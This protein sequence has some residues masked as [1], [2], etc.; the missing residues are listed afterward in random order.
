MSNAFAFAIYLVIVW[1]E[2]LTRLS[3]LNSGRFFSTVD[4]IVN[5]GEQALSVIGLS[6][7]IVHTKRLKL[8]HGCLLTLPSGSDNRKIGAHLFKRAHQRDS[9][10]VRHGEVS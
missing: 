2:K 8:S 4:G 3:H 9:I 7:E 10:H 5:C 6:Q 1:R